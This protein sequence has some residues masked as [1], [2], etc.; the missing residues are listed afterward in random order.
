VRRTV[1][2]IVLVAFA[3]A[4]VVL[5]VA[6]W[7]AY[8][9]Y[10]TEVTAVMP[11]VAGVKATALTDGEAIT[12]S[13]STSTPLIVDGYSHEP[14]LQITAHGILQ[15]SRSPAVQ[16]N[17]VATIGYVRPM[18]AYDKAHPVWKQIAT[19]DITQWHDHRIHWMG[20][21]APPAAQADPDHP[22]LIKT[23]TI[24][25]TY[26]T[27]AGYIRGTL[28]SEPPSG[29]KKY[30]T[31]AAIALGVVVMALVLVAEVRRTRR[32]PQPLAATPAGSGGEPDPAK[33]PVE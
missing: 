23:W 20:A 28:Y 27:Q 13:N 19:D 26:G 4:A 15:N 32:P 24:P 5:V 1:F 2:V 3:V 11:Q 22:H 8:T 33:E 10:R 31:W 18:S 9:T 12:V 29:A 16:L 17:R 7:P 14:Y 30:I 6:K 21:Q 25:I